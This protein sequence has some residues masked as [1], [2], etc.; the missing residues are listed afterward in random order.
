MVEPST[1]LNEAD[2]EFSPL[3]VIAEHVYR[4]ESSY[5]R[6]ETRRMIKNH[7]WGRLYGKAVPSMLK[8]P[9]V[10]VENLLLGSKEP[11]SFSQRVT[12]CS[13]PDDDALQCNVTMLCSGKVWLVGPSCIIG[14]G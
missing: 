12:G 5:R 9:S 11:P 14:G 6:S 3:F 10:L 1:T 13:L 4:P 7:R 2:Q 8:V